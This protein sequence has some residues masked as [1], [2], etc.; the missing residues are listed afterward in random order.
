MNEIKLFP[1]SWLKSFNEGQL[2]R[3]AIMTIDGGLSDEEAL[4]ASGLKVKI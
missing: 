3:L 1:I 2:E 4:K